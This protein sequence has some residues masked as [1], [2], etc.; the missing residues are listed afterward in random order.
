MKIYNVIYLYC[1]EKEIYLTNRAFYDLDKAVKYYEEKRLM[2]IEMAR[3]DD[4]DSDEECP[5]DYTIDE[6]RYV[7]KCYVENEKYLV[8]LMESTVS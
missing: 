6:T 2:A 4:P 1:S 8:R 7:F 3:D 5:R